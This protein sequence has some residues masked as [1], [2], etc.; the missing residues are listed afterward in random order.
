MKTRMVM[1]AICCLISVALNNFVLAQPDA[2]APEK[3]LADI[4]SREADGTELL[5]AAIVG[6]WDVIKY[7]SENRIVTGPAIFSADGTLVDALSIFGY[8]TEWKVQ[9]GK[10]LLMKPASDGGEG[11]DTYN[12]AFLA[13]AR[14]NLAK[15]HDAYFLHKTT[16][17]SQEYGSA[18]HPVERVAGSSR[19]AGDRVVTR[20]VNVR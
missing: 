4:Q 7:D 12:V 18:I 16:E 19:Y 9:N 14:I 15:G 2:G 11:V 10:V 8:A 1:S 17:V 3:E 5:S 20:Q 6:T 13:D